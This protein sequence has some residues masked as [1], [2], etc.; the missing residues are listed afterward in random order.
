MLVVAASSSPARACRGDDG[1][2]LV[3]VSWQTQHDG[4]KKVS[5]SSR[6]LPA[7][8]ASNFFFEYFCLLS[9]GGI[10]MNDSIFSLELAAAAS[11]NYRHGELTTRW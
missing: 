8:S 1:T 10:R 5:T 3:R 9:S 11:S 2:E 7:S 4:M 6:P